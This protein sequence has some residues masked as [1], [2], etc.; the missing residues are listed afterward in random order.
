LLKAFNLETYCIFYT[1]LLKQRRK[2]LQA[3]LDDYGREGEADYH[4]HWIKDNAHIFKES[5]GYVSKSFI[6][7][8]YTW[9]SKNQ[10]T[11]EEANIK[12][13]QVIKLRYEPRHQKKPIL[14]E[15]LII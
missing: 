15:N 8:A 2:N 9:H 3:A 7:P 13:I 11:L 1:A 10:S 12:S 4:K 6:P 5:F 14:T